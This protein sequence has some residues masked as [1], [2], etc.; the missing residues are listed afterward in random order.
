MSID[1]RPDFLL[2]SSATSKLSS[3]Y[4]FYETDYSTTFQNNMKEATF[5]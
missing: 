1:F 2:S 3:K 4:N 5:F